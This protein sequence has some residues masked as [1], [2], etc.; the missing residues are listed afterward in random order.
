MKKLFLA[1]LLFCSACF[2]NAAADT[3]NSDSSETITIGIADEFSPDF[4]PQVLGPTLEYLREALPHLTIKTK[5]VVLQKTDALKSS[6]VDLF[7]APPLIFWSQL[8]E[9]G[10]SAIG[11]LSPS[12]SKDPRTSTA[13]VL[14]TKADRTDLKNE[15]DLSSKKIAVRAKG[16]NH[17]YLLLKHWLSKKRIQLEKSADVLETGFRNPGV[18]SAVLSGEVDFGLLAYCELENALK[19]GALEPGKIKV[20]SESQTP[21]EVCS[22]TTELFPNIVVGAYPNTPSDKAAAITAALYDMPVLKNTYRWSYANGFDSLDEVAKELALGPYRYL[23]EWRPEALWKR[24]STEILL[25]AAL[26]L[27]AAWH[28][29]RVNRLVAL[30]TEELRTALIEKQ[31]L[32]EKEKESR[33]KLSTLEKNGLISHLSSLIAHE[34]KQ[35]LGAITNYTAGLRAH[36]AS[37]QP[38]PELVNH[39]LDKISQQSRDASSVIEFVR[40]FAK[41]SAPAGIVKCDPSSVT[42]KAIETLRLSGNFSGEIYTDISRTPWCSADPKGLELALYNVLKNAAEACG[43]VSKSCINVTIQEYDG[44]V[45]FSI[46][47]NGPTLTED[48]VQRILQTRIST[49][50]EGLGLGMKIVENIV[51][52]C[53]GRLELLRNEPSGLRV[54]IQIPIEKP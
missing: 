11:M 32:S 47:D 15:K 18:L 31:K 8:L 40:S 16:L 22:R 30:R 3:R 46:A 33:E 6:N 19:S 9:D 2:A 27:A 29:F 49:K 26:V 37:G 50:K 4:W 51:E 34:L 5:E 24:F 1:L 25:F 53:G 20:V 7:I 28:I 23:Q 21:T 48:D 35:P 17:E 36:L 42:Q 54:L 10:A 44:Y 45:E 43:H 52:K 14:I 12:H 41:P 39:V 13:G 38:D